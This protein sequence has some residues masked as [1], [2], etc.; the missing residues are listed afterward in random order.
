MGGYYYAVKSIPRN[1]LYYLTKKL[2]QERKEKRREA[3]RSLLHIYCQNPLR[4][5]Y[6][7]PLSVLFAPYSPFRDTSS[8]RC[9]AMKA[10]LVC[11]SVSE[12]SKLRT[13]TGM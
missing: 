2:K 6:R 7:L 11:R 4:V 3:K 13:H 5:L 8:A 12:I 10:V 9:N 1:L